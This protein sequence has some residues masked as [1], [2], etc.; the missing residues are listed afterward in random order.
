MAPALTPSTVAISNDVLLQVLLILTEKVAATERRT[1]AA[2]TWISRPTEP[3]RHVA[4]S[5]DDEAD[6]AS[7]GTMEEPRSRQS[8]GKVGFGLV[9]THLNG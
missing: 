6:E 7:D 2:E 3:A 4:T 5:D 8:K 9:T 1:S